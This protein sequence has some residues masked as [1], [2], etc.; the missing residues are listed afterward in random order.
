MVPMPCRKRDHPA[1]PE[2]SIE[3]TLAALEATFLPKDSDRPCTCTAP[4]AALGDV[5]DQCINH[6]RG[7]RVSRPKSAYQQVA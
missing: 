6:E 1:A 5:H 7:W 4:R 3:L 2:A